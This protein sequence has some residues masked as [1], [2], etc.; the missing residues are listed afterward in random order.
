[1]QT[2]QLHVAKM[3]SALSCCLTDQEYYPLYSPIKLTKDSAER[4]ATLLAMR[5]QK[6]HNALQFSIQFPGVRS[7]RQV[8][9]ALSFYK[10]NIEIIIS[11]QLGHI[12]IRDDYESVEEEAFH[13]RIIS[14]NE[15]G[16][17]TEGNV[18][19]FRAFFEE[20]E[21]GYNGQPCAVL[22][23]DSVDEDQR[24]PYVSQKRVRKDLS[25]AVVLTED[26]SATG[27]SDVVV[28]MRRAAFYKIR[29]PEFPI[30]FCEFENLRDAITQWSDVML[31]TIRG[32]LY[33]A[34][35]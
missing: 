6:I 15:A 25:T 35:A 19:S 24:Y 20:N 34:R 29:Q 1:M 31:K 16:I 11:E 3:Q 21:G 2:Q 22:V 7:L 26:K 4:R 10:N 12:T 33:P 9:D 8:Y 23:A 28:T 13:G 30:S 27:D 14:T 18:V 32:I 17:T 5:D